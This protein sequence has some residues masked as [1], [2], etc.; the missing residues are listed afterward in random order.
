MEA[1]FL[2]T[3][4]RDKLKGGASAK[5]FT[6][7][8]IISQEGGPKSTEMCVIIEGQVGVYKSMPQEKKIATLT[9]GDFFGEMA[10]F[11]DKEHSATVVAETDVFLMVI[12]REA[13]FNFMETQPQ[14]IFAIIQTLCDRLDKANRRISGAKIPGTTIEPIPTPQ[15]VAPPPPPPAPPPAAGL[16]SDMPP[17]GFAP[18]PPKKTTIEMPKDLFPADHDVYDLAPA[19]KPAELVYK[20][21]FKCPVCEKS[22]Q[23]YSV[24][25]TRLKLLNR[26][27]DFRS[28]YQ[29][30]DTAYY[31]IITCPECYFSM[32]ETG[33]NQHIIARFKESIGQIT[34][35]KKHFGKINLIEDRSINPVF[36]GYYLALKGAPLFYK[37]HHMNTAKLWLRLMWLYDDVK[38]GA[39]KDYAAR[40]AHASYL[41]AFE[42]TDITGEAIQQ[43]SVLMG[44]LSLVIKDLPSAKTFFVKARSNKDGNKSLLSQA[45]DGIE[46]IRRIESGQIQL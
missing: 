11:L 12:T 35:Y 2:K 19:P 16:I 38:D 22:F 39:M 27:K 3:L 29:D 20:K 28:H 31:E 13:V 26:D 15:P 6:A 1:N 42:S 43:L 24:R 21:T 30:I 4:D 17:E 33:F 8:Q 7:G 34:R 18:P 46:T 44:E 9:K 23:A 10:L 41:S 45:E 36:I 25:T 40:K 5:K 37:N 32:L 14:L